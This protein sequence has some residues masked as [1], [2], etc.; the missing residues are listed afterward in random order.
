M[1]AIP[2]ILNCCVEGLP[3][4]RRARPS[5]EERIETNE[6]LLMT[7]LADEPEIFP[8][9]SPYLR[10]EHFHEGVFRQAAEGY[11]KIL[12]EQGGG[13]PASVIGMFESQQEQELAASMFNT[14]LKGISDA[15]ERE[16]ALKD[17]VISI[18]KAAAEK[19]RRQIEDQTQEP[20]AQM[21]TKMLQTRKE[22]QALQKIQ[23]TLNSAEN[24]Q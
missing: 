12:Q 17:I 14:R 21:L 9:I 23:F 8:Q 6:K 7:W 16:K 10:P 24:E 22:L 11:W 1:C 3:Q 2:I 20:S 18:R 13:N 5:R 4:N 15:R 19:E